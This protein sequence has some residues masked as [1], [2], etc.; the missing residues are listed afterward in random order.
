[1]TLQP[2][3]RVRTCP[4][5][6]HNDQSQSRFK[7][8]KIMEDTSKQHTFLFPDSVFVYVQ[9]CVC[10]CVFTLSELQCVQVQWTL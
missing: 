10:M 1:M 9:V 8:P 3:N 5:G 2:I 6:H 4:D 7:I